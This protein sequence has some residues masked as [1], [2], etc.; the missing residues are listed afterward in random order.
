M[1]HTVTLI[2]KYTLYGISFGCTFLVAMCLAYS[3]W[4]R[5]DLLM[6]VSKD[7]T[8]Q[9]IGAMAV[10][11]AC[12]GTS[13]IYQFNHP[14]A[15]LKTAIHFCIG[16]GVFYPTAIYLSWIPFNPG[17]MLDTA[18]QFFLSCSIF[19]VIWFCFYL[20]NR[21]EAKRINK[22]LRELEQENAFYNG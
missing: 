19:I 17:Q 6:M 4:D 9:S 1:K 5:E 21:N 14:S 8:R 13:V 2:I 3:L 7:F 15:F 10:G 16:M 20:F 22:R 18:L 11:I 12:G